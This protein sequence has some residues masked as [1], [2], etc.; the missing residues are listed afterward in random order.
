MASL[1]DLLRSCKCSKPAADKRH[2]ATAAGYLELPGAKKD[3]DCL[4]VRVAGGVSMLLGC[5][6][7]FDY[8]ESRKKDFR[9]GSCK[10][11]EAEHG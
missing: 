1:A 11:L 2:S 7:L 10:H 6:N 8:N 4:K 3:G 9:C 5:C